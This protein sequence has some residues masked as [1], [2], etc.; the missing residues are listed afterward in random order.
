MNMIVQYDGMHTADGLYRLHAPGCLAASLH[1]ANES[2][3]LPN[4]T[5]LAYVP[6][7]SFGNG[8]YRLRGG[9]GIPQPATHI[10]VRTV[11]PDFT[12]A[13]ERCFP[14]PETQKDSESPHDVRFC[15]MSDL[16]LAAKPDRIRQ[17]LK[18]ASRADC[19]LLPGGLTSDASPEQFSQLRSLIEEECGQTPVLAISGK[20]DW[21]PNT[22]PFLSVWRIFQHELL[23]RAQTLGATVW[24]DKSG[25]YAAAFR[26]VSIY[27]L[28]FAMNCGGFDSLRRRQLA[29]LDDWLEADTSAYPRLILCYT[30]LAAHNP[31]HIRGDVESPYFNMDSI[32]QEILD[33]RGRCVFLS[34]RMHISLNESKGCVER[35]EAHRNLYVNDSSVCPTTFHEE[36]M[37]SEQAWT[38]G[39]MVWMD[40]GR[41]QIALDGQTISSQKWIARGCYRV[42]L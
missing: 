8:A 24:K 36:E 13:E 38:D 20:H 29:L 5:A 17:A 22:T 2:G 30:P 14:I 37:L 7:D 15:V 28:D 4:F 25:A 42:N 31:L 19:I 35:D 11:T 3:A 18:M 16:H 10:Q 26:G 34:G 21:L 41:D 33:R 39:A 9:R 40:V 27:G 32:L 1:W 6:L 23:R 12:L